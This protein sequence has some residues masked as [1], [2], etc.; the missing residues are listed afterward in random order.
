M[1]LFA[2]AFSNELGFLRGFFSDMSS[3]SSTYSLTCFVRAGD[4]PL[5]SAAGMLVGFMIGMTGG[6]IMVE[7]V[8]QLS[9]SAHELHD[10]VETIM[11]ERT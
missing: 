1:L 5:R 9:D 7:S 8:K 10:E 3:S 11:I 4:P 6:D 2:K